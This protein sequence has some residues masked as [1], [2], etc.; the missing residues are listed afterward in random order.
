LCKF[1]IK[2]TYIW[3]IISIL[4]YFIRLYYIAVKIIKIILRV[5]TNISIR[6][7]L[8]YLDIV[9]LR[10]NGIILTCL[11]VCLLGKAQLLLTLGLLPINGLLH[12]RSPMTSIW[13]D[14]NETT[15]WWQLLLLLSSYLTFAY[16]PGRQNKGGKTQHK[17]PRN[18]WMPQRKNE[19]SGSCEVTSG[20]WGIK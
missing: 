17:L 11:H 1:Y 12:C 8:L 4:S 3:Y 20:K 5:C 15:F 19:V 18:Q 16:W 9:V 13:Q 7:D 2:Y 10:T 14:T 6:T